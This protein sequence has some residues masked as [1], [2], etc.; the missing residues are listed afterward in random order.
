M[1]VQ[2]GWVVLAGGEG[3]LAGAGCELFAG[4]GCPAGGVEAGGVDAW[5]VEADGVE[6]GG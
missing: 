2:F 6:A 5:G 4:A 3:G 1:L